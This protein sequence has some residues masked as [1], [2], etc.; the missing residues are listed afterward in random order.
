ARAERLLTGFASSARAH[1]T[2]Q[3]LRLIAGLAMV[4][5]APEMQLSNLFRAFGWLLVLTAAGLL[6]IPWRWHRRFGE[7]A[8]PLAIKHMKLFALGA[9]ALGVFILYGVFYAI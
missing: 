3:A 8:I 7:W 5:F 4:L 2:E 1:Y 9:F 6:L